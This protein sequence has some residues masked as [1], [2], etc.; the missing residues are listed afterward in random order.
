VPSRR[1]IVLVCVTMG[2]NTV[3]VGA[4]PALL[5]EIGAAVRLADWQLGAVAGAFGFARMLA[6]VPVGLFITHHLARALTV[7]PLFLVSGALAMTLGGEFS[8]V[9][10]GRVLMGTGH[11]LSMLAGLT[12]V[13]RHRAGPG[14]ASSLNALEFSSM[15]GVLGGVSLVAFL[16]RTVPWPTAFLLACAPVLVSLATLPQLRRALP[17]SVDGPRP[18]FSRS[19]AAVPS[20][21]VRSARLALL[22]GV[23]GTAI[24]LSYSAV[25]QFVIPLRGSREFGLERAG[26]ARLLML[27]QLV[28]IVALLPVGALADRHG[29]ARVVAAIM[30][31][32]TAALSLIGFGTLPMMAVGCAL[33]GLGMAG[34]MLP[35]GI[36]RSA[37]PPGQVAWRVA[38]YRVSIDGAM[39]LGPVLAGL[40][41]A[42]HAGA[43]PAA[44]I[45][46]MVSLAVTLLL[47]RRSPM[48]SP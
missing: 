18:L 4:F 30:L 46:V 34:W 22:A 10:L 17:S 20:S 2:V 40:L 26:I 29:T 41:G 39:F 38:L 36:L 25:D 13:L 23:V 28:D 21:P 1:L 8:T 37:T 6:D 3:S 44:L 16:P 11:T 19:D 24:A 42:R 15:L 47:Q 45:V 12:T 35:L 7:A 9:L 14:L 48:S 43:L 27:S 32:F 33:F 31:S 5:P